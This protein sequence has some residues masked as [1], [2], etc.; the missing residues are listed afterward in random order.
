MSDEKKVEAKEEKASDIAKLAKQVASL[1]FIVRKTK[2][3]LEEKMGAD[4]DGDGRVGSGPYKKIGGLILVACLAFSAQAED[5]TAIAYWSTNAKITAAGFVGDA[6]IQAGSINNLTI[7]TNAAVNGAASVGSTLVVSG[8]LSAVS[9]FTGTGKITAN[10]EVE[11]NGA[12]STVMLDINGANTNNVITVDVTNTAGKNATAFI[13]IEDARTGTFANDTNEATIRINAAGTY[14]IAVKEGIVYALD[15]FEGIGSSLTAL[16]AANITAGGA[17]SAINGLAITN[18]DGANLATGTIPNA[19]L[20]SD[21]QQLAN[22]DAGGLTNLPDTGVSGAN[23]SKLAVNN[24]VSLT[25]I[26]ASG[27]SDADLVKLAGNDGSSLTN[28]GDVL[29]GTIG[30]KLMNSNLAGFTNVSGAAI[31]NGNI[32]YAAMSNGLAD[33]VPSKPL[34]VIATNSG[35]NA[36]GYIQTRNIAGG[37]MAEQR[38]LRIWNS[39]S[40]YGAAATNGI[41]ALAFTG[42]T[43]IQ[44][45]TANADYKYATGATGTNGIIINTIAA[46]STNYIMVSDGGSVTSTAAITFAGP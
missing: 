40:A 12:A 27:L 15:G 17:I 45:I 37:V 19:R 25:N 43:A 32:P 29:T 44:T 11:I 42:G 9:T 41:D 26:P 5:K 30:T 13:A 33:Y 39:T 10:E 6:T 2:N 28:V 7:L 34:I 1:A 16:S 31:Q 18:L 36:T 23:L 3:W 35:T 21:L 38:I 20:D 4:L 24:G 8:A 22:D 46:G 14:A